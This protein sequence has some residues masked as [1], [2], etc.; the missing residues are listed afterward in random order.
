[1]RVDDDTGATD[2][3]IPGIAV[4]SSGNAY[5]VWQDN[6]NGDADV[7]F[8]YR[9][10][11]GAWQPN[12]RIDDATESTDADYA[13]IAVDSSGTAYAV[14][15]DNRNGNYD[16]YFSCCLSG[17]SWQPNVRVDDATGATD[18]CRPRI[19]VDSSGSA[20]GVWYDIR[21]GNWDIYSSN[22][23]SGGAWQSNVRVDDA[24]GSTDAYNPSIAVD[25]LGNAYAIWYDYRYGNWD[26]YFS[27]CPS[28]GLWQANIRVDDATG[29]TDAGTP[30][31]AVDSSGNAYAVWMD[32]RN[33]NY[34]IYFSLYQ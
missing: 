27:Y 11:G 24:T 15:R 3:M 16:I 13:S 6:R 18:A 1:V 32:L 31:I 33:G 10:S 19:A 28:A 23:P 7:Y 8:S 20:Y 25:P 26:I 14:W 12:V 30:S 34:D 29:S 4:D 21:N 2:A 9:P 17:S 5:A 22:C